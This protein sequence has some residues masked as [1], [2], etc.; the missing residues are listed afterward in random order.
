MLGKSN[1]NSTA[2]KPGVFARKHMGD[3]PA[4]A[5]VC[6]AEN[7]SIYNG[8]NLTM[9]GSDVYTKNLFLL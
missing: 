9:A 8:F 4:L 3:N 7:D 5:Q 6:G 1:D 2:T